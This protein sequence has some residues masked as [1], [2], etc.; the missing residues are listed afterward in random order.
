[1]KRSEGNP[2]NAYIAAFPP[3]VRR[4]LNE[5]RAAIQ[6][7]APDAQ[8]TISYGIPTF[9]LH[10]HLVHFAAYREHVGFYPDPSGIRAFQKE[11][12]GYDTSAGTVRFPLGRPLPLALVRKIVKFRA[13]ENRKKQ[14]ART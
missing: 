1:M 9:D 12:S 8:E 13:A 6:A 5:L 10:G 4:T 3:A 14:R 7:A 2:V 11:L